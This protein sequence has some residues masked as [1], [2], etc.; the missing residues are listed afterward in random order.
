MAKHN[1]CEKI[2]SK[3][4]KKKLYKM[5]NCKSCDGKGYFTDVEAVG[6]T[7]PKDPY[8]KPHIERCDDCLYF[9]S[10]VDAAKFHKRM[11]AA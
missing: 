6:I 5:L 4:F 7:D 10:D 3:A 1:S 9:D 8:S 11:E 2:I